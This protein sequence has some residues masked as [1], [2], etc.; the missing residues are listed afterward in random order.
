[1]NSVYLCT[2][3]PLQPLGYY[4]P[5]P[6]DERLVQL[7][8]ASTRGRARALAQRT[9][10]LECVEFTDWRLRKIGETEEIEGVLP[11]NSPW[12]EESF[13]DE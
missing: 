5:G 3:D 12:W 13:E 1:M 10:N 8:V 9:V 4:P 6:P 7:V 11:H 2:T